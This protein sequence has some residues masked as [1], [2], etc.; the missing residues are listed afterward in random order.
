MPRIMILLLLLAVTLL[1]AEEAPVPTV[2]ALQTQIQA[3]SDS[4]LQL[5][6]SEVFS[7]YG[8]RDTDQLHVVAAKLE[9][10]NIP[11]WKKYLELEP[12]NP[13]LDKMSLRKLGISP[14]RAVLAQQYSIYGFTELSTLSELA[15]QKHLPVKQLRAFAGLKSEQKQFDSYSLQSLNITPEELVRFENEFNANRLKFGL[16]ITGTGILMV[17][18]ALA[19]TALVIGQLKR[20]NPKPQ[21]ASGTLKVTSGGKVVS[22]PQDL[23]S[24]II[25]AA[26]A[27]L[28]LYIQSIEER[29]RLLLTFHRHRSDQ[30]HG[31][32]LLN[33][34]N[35]DLSRPRR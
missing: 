26:I 11:Q 33:M 10:Q 1:G 18:F 16:S 34:P 5:R 6:E 31:S 35:R 21:E 27:A 12:Q 13:V 15:W 3:M 25:A 24:D 32:A 19:V 30:W 29:R 14:Y 28:H 20:L 2:E 9:I 8:F 23:N 22:H 4:L 7:E 17:F